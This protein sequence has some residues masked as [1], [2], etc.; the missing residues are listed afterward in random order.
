MSLRVTAVLMSERMHPIAKGEC[1]QIAFA[2]SRA[3][4]SGVGTADSTQTVP[5]LR[6][7]WTI[8]S[9]SIASGA[10]VQPWR[11]RYRGTKPQ[12][13]MPAPS[14]VSTLGMWADRPQNR[15]RI[16]EDGR[17]A[18]AA[19]A[20]LEAAGIDAQDEGLVA[21]ARAL[22]GCWKGEPCW[23]RTSEAAYSAWNLSVLSSTTT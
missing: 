16:N 20:A 4:S 8:E 1:W 13:N 22:N 3:V 21:A 2:V 19:I 9:P 6:R 18:L 12:T 15:G 17:R 10:R 5:F 14:I 11:R 7:M 23:R